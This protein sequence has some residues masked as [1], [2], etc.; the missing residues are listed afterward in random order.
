MTYT[1]EQERIKNPS[2]LVRP[3][4]FNDAMLRHGDYTVY[5]GDVDGMHI[6]YKRGIACILDLKYQPYYTGMVSRTKKM[7]EHL[8]NTLTAGGMTTYVIIAGHN[9]DYDKANGDP[10]VS[11]DDCTVLEVYTAN[12]WISYD[13]SNHRVSDAIETIKANYDYDALLASLIPQC[14]TKTCN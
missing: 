8:A 11:I 2:Y 13:K 9:V 3:V 4:I 12:K 7:Y 10:R 6:D 14:P 5:N 1:A